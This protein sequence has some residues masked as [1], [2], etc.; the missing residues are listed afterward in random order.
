MWF[1]NR[2]EL[3]IPWLEAATAWQVVAADT[4][5]ARCPASV[6]RESWPVLEKHESPTR[7]LELAD[8]LTEL[9]KLVGRDQRATRVL[10]AARWYANVTDPFESAETMARNPYVSRPLAE[11]AALVAGTEGLGPVLSTAPVLRVSARW[12]GEPVH[13]VDKGSAGRMVVA[14]MVGGSVF[15]EDGTD[16]RFAQAALIELAHSVCRP[17]RPQCDVCPLSDQCAWRRTKDRSSHRRA[18]SAL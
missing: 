17:Q 16:T 12:S 7:T 15:D 13:K 14:R 18:S 9:A 4:L 10:S 8:D 2:E 5:L 11:L 3:D 1:L 6:S